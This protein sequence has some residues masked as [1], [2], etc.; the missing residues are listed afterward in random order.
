MI[1]HKIMRNC[2]KHVREK[3]LT[4]FYLIVGCGGRI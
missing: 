3:N 2:K 1:P 4:Y